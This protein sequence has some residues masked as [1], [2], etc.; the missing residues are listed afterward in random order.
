MHNF[1]HTYVKK[2]SPPSGTEGIQKCQS[3]RLSIC[4]SPRKSALTFEGGNGSARNFQGPPNS[5]QVIFGG[6]TRTPG[7]SGS[8]PDPEK[9]GLRQIYLLRGFE[10]GGVVSY[11]FGIGRTTPTKCWERNFDF[12]PS[13]K[14]NGASG[15]GLPGG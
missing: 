6:V 10:A 7:P 1:P 3:V 15:R 12:R 13:A 14:N 11:L 5:L 2:I 8:G 4:L 9:W